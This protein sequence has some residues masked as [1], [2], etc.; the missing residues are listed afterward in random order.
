VY[1]SFYGKTRKEA[2]GKL[3][4]AWRQ[5]DSGTLTEPGSPTVARYLDSWL[6]SVEHSVRPET[7]RSYALNVRRVRPR[8]GRVRLDQLRASHVQALYA[9]LLGEGLSKRSVQQCGVVLGT[10]LNAALRLGLVS[11]NVCERATKPRQE[12][13]EDT[14]LTAE[15]LLHLFDVT[16]HD[17]LHALWVVLGIEGL[18]LGEALGVKWADIDF[19]RGTLTVR[20]ALQRQTGRGLVEVEPK[21]RTS[22]RTV[23]L[24]RLT[25]D[26]LEHHQT[27][28][29]FEREKASSLYQDRDF[30]FASEVGGPLEQSGVFKHWKAAL[31]KAG[32]PHIRRHDLRHTSATL[33]LQGG[34]TLL[35]VKHRLGHSNIGVTDRYSHITPAMRRA[36]V[37]ARERVL[38]QADQV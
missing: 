31:D 2:L 23:D 10:A 35:E 34:E 22:R 14:T 4:E 20:R 26:A 17:R 21:S 27:M 38:G 7:Y 28:Q 29:R 1:R 36:S 9:K 13:G 5:Q 12:R 16:A 32:L 33:G 8:I 37:E 18:R 19:K 6:Q 3:Q 30:V 15:Q 11:H 24:T 25:I